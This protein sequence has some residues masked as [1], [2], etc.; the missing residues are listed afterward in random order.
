MINGLE[1]Q[2][3]L[4]R[5]SRGSWLLDPVGTLSGR[6]RRWMIAAC[7]VLVLAWCALR[8]GGLLAAWGLPDVQFYVAM[9]H[10]RYDL[11]PQ[12]F[13]S[14]PLAPLLARS[15]ANLAHCRVE[16][17]FEALAYV[18]LF[19]ALLAVFWLLSR[20]KA[21]R[22]MILAVAIVPFWPQLLSFAGLPDPLYTAL[23]AA[24]LVA[25]E[26]GWVYVAAGL[27]LPLML[28][29]ES[30][31]LVLLCLL[32]VC[33]RRLRWGGSA[34]A[35]GAA[36]TGA[37]LVKHFSAG[38]LPNP[39]HLS[40][41]TYMFGKIMSN[42]LRS[43]GVVPWSNVYPYLCNAPA[44]QMRLRLGGVETVG[45]CSW[46]ISAPMQAIWAIL[47]SFGVLPMLLIAPRRRPRDTFPHGDLLLPFCLLYGGISLLLA[48]ALG[49][50]Y[51]RLV[52]YAWPLPL[53]AVPRLSGAA[54][55]WRG[56]GDEKTRARLLWCGALMLVHGG[57]C[58]LGN[59]IGTVEEVAAAVTL[60]LGAVA[61]I[62]VHPQGPQGS[63]NRV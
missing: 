1:Q 17:G 6:S 12:P 15:I 7:P 56:P 19:T 11:V 5:P 24:L 34:L 57:L 54:G 13:S 43:L 35:I 23:L 22:W 40:G 33:G 46:E 27:M 3:T 59:G 30:T 18:S 10:G 31:V 36:I 20:S 25:L 62:L 63:L 60:Q 39:E 26:T 47:T 14:R 50:W 9:A 41:G 28:A 51:V 16:D 55:L 44:W 58:A 53:V 42:S 37:A 29:R 21:P 61:L 4:Q 2:K 48:P 45:V 49:T 38:G 52:G 8:N 32:A